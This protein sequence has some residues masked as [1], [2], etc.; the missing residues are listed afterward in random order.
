[1]VNHEIYNFYN[2]IIIKYLLVDKSNFLEIILNVSNVQ[3]WPV[4]VISNRNEF[5]SIF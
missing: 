2:S 3:S 5:Y 4:K 1:M